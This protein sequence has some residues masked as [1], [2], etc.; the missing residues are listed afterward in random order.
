M[1]PE[2]PLKFSLVTGNTPERQADVAQLVA[3]HLAK[4]RVAGSNPVV[5]SERPRPRGPGPPR[6]S[7]REARQRP[8]KPCTRVQIP[9]PPRR[10]PPRAIGAVG[11]RFLDTEEVTGSNPVSPTRVSAG[12]RLVT[13]SSVTSRSRC[14][15][16]RWEHEIIGAVWSW[17]VYV[18]AISQPLVRPTAASIEP[19][20]RARALS[21]CWSRRSRVRSPTTWATTGADAEAESGANHRKGSR[22][23]AA[24][25]EVEVRSSNHRLPRNVVQASPLRV[26][27]S[28]PLVCQSHLRDFTSE[29]YGPF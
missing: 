5:R 8:A 16:L 14:G 25:G 10:S 1:G 11:A 6:W 21:G 22:A 24:V 18:G 7:G 20:I 19:T 28:A 12:Q 29:G 27:R 23:K 26:G 4:V 9:S 3:H 13:G 17:G 15:P 2:H